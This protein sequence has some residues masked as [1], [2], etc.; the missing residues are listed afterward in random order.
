VGNVEFTATGWDSTVAKDIF[1][2]ANPANMPAVPDK[3]YAS[4]DPWL[5]G[6][7]GTILITGPVYNAAVTN[8]V[9]GVGVGNWLPGGLPFAVMCW[10]AFQSATAE[11]QFICA[12]VTVSYFIQ[13]CSL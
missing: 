8:N 7:D 1:T 2:I 5:N 6:S 3:G 4:G 9:V 13:Q 10:M 12:C 11:A